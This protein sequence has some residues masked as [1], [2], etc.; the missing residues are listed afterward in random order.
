VPALA[1]GLRPV[2]TGGVLM[3]A[4]TVEG[5]PAPYLVRPPRWLFVVMG[6]LWLIVAIVVLS[7]DTSSAATIGY[8]MAFLLLFAGVEEL[9]ATFLAPGWKWLHAA[10]GVVFL[11]TGA[12]ALVSPLQT[13]GILAM[14][15][16]WYLMIKGFSSVFIAVALRDQLPLWGLGLAAGIIEIVIGL[17]ALGYPGR[18]AWLLVLWVGIGALM[19]G[20]S[21]LVAAFTYGGAR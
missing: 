4:I 9:A 20:I 14:L 15:V 7:F 5:D 16:G 10:L 12:M 3:A 21:D 18:S 6:V 17:W 8:M 1:A 13:F 2:M 19:R 11:I